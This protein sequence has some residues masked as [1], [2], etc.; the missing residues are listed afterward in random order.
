M[1]PLDP[2]LT[3]YASGVRRL[4]VVSV[5]LGLASAVVVVIQ[6]VLIAGL[7]AEV[8][9]GGTAPADLAGR[10][11][12]LAAVIA[13][14]AALAWA[15]EETAG[16]SATTVTAGLRRDLLVH[17]AA[18]GP[19]WRSAEHGGRLA[20]LA[21]TGVE[22]LHTYL[23][24]YLPQLVLSVVVPV[25]ML[26]YLFG[27][28]LTSGIIVLVTL[29]LIPLF[30][31]LVGW[32]T[33]RQTR[34][35]WAS[36]ARLATHF[37][38]VVA[39]LPTL[40]VFGRAKAQAEAVRRVTDDYRRSSMVTLRVAFLSS[41]ILELLASLSVALVAV[42]IGLRLVYG[43]LT[44]Q[45]GLAVLILAPEAYLPLRQLGTQFHAAADGVEAAGRVLDVLETRPPTVG[46][47]QDVTAPIGLTLD[48]AAVGSP[49]E[50]GAV[51]PLTM[52]LPA[53]QITVVTGPSGA[54][55]TTLLQLIAGVVR[56]DSGA[57]LVRSGTGDE[58]PVAD[59][60]PG[61]WR[62]R[63]GWAAQG[64]ALQSGTIR[65]NLALGSPDADDGALRAALEAVDAAGF[66]DALPAGWQHR[67]G[68]GGSGLSQGQ[69]Q[70]LT[71]ARAL[72]RPVPV[73]LL[74]EPTAA[75]D[76]ATEQRVLAGIRRLAAGRTVVLVTHRPG[77]IALADQVVRL[78]ADGGD[79]AFGGPGG[80]GPAEP[81]LATT[82]VNPW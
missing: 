42:A 76:E 73:L 37:T 16:R 58:V 79:D 27:A 70:R 21:T 68:D 13:A 30:M 53:G 18:L 10:L 25:V 22:S 59:I 52:D 45:V 24:R 44:L 23:A 72:A 74:D 1:R 49:G 43:D 20:V 63:L 69:R 57:V 35:K 28:D 56:P 50:R 36:L 11:G 66:V 71:L 64:G 6:A 81:A 78:G 40:K 14:R 47:R 33:D 80:D 9:I 82:A 12:A 46:T 54:G 17:A 26:I 4:L 48:A 41:M 3:R 65:E 51:G 31:A 34:A 5:A 29:P 2:R 75:L 38:D 77:P 7:L 39:G 61:W 67:L 55:K 15:A 60:E 62:S 19:R 8:I 32:Y